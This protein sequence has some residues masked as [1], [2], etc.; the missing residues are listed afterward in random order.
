MTK[1]SSHQSGT[2]TKLLLLGDSGSGKTGALASLAAAG[3]DLWFID[4]DNGLDILKNALMDPRSSYPRDALDRVHYVTVTDPMKQS[5]GKLIPVKASTWTKVSKIL[6][7]DEPWGDEPKR[8]AVDMTEKDVLVIDSLTFLS[9][10]AL[11]FNL[12]MNARLGQKPFQSDWYDGQ[13]AVESLLEMLY[14]E[15][16]KC[17]VVV[18]SHITYIGEENSTQTGYPATLGKA[19]SPKVGRYFNSILQAKTVGYGANQKRVILTNTSNMVELKNS[20]P[21]GVKKEYPL[22]TGLAD[23]FRDVRLAAP[24]PTAQSSTLPAAAMDPSTAVSTSSGPSSAI[25]TKK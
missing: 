25:S 1:L 16:I 10:A 15:A 11:A 18:I 14:D 9:K 20:N 5:G 22:E 21:W 7:G 23:F 4:V 6:S 12:S 2:T 8:R 19:L 24:S 13:L 17:N 3:Y